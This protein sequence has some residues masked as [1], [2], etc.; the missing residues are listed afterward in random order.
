M[1][2]KPIIE[3]ALLITLAVV[4][5]AGGVYIPLVGVI[6]AL[7]SPVPLVILGMRYGLKRGVISGLTSS[8]LLLLITGPFQAFIFLFNSAVVAIAVGYLVGKGLKANEVILYS[9]LVS[10][11]SKIVFFALSALIVGVNPLEVNLKLIQDSLRSSAEIYEKFG[12]AGRDSYLLGRNLENFL[13]Y[14]RM[15]FPAVIIVA[16]ALDAFLTFVVSGW[17]LKKIGEPFPELPSFSEWR[18]P[19]SLLWGMGLGVIFSILGEEMTNFYLVSAGANLQLVF[20]FLFILQ[21][22]SLADYFM[23]RFR[24]HKWV[25][26]LLIFLSF[27]SASI[28]KDSYVCWDDRC[29]R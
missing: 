7:F 17:I 15:V 5:F 4:L 2:A 21:G 23:K 24:F 13:G 11:M 3:G 18:F 25:R 22:I 16:S 20:G 14:L 12:L 28:I 26:Y 10:L 6:L 19:R 9:A 27:L 29:S 1:R 8:F